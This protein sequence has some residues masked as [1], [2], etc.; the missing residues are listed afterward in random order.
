MRSRVRL[1]ALLLL[2]LLPA[3]ALAAPHHHHH[4]SLHRRVVLA[5][6][7][8]AAPA[9]SAPPPAIV[10]ESAPEPAFLPKPTASAPAAP[11]DEELGP[12]RLGLMSGGLVLFVVG[13]AADAGVTYGFHHDPA[14]VSLI[15]L[16]GPLVQCGEHYGY[17]G[18]MVQT[19]NADFD[20]QMN[21][22]I[23]QASTLI[24]TV[25]YVGLA[26]D[27]AGQL[28]GLIMT[29]AGAATHSHERTHSPS[30]SR[31]ALVPT[32]SGGSALAVTF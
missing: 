28:A 1:I 16:V 14:G 10:V 18:P 12:R 30:S 19:G 3:S 2:L 15:P 22:Q 5:E 32:A 20:R 13:Y 31:L 26:L 8:T 21:A 27:F 17:S 7:L 4:K 25:T 6:A 29:I 9:E 23:H 24:A 11:R